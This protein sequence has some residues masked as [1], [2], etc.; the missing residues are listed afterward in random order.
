M[1]STSTK[2]VVCLVLGLLYAGAAASAQA[3]TF[4]VGI[5]LPVQL[6]LAPALEPALKDLGIG[7][8]NYYLKTFVNSQ[9]RPVAETGP[10][11]LDLVGRLGLDWSIA[12]Y[13][14][15]PPDD[16][17]RDAVAASAQAGR[18]GRFRGV[19]F[20][21]LEHI[22]LLNFNRPLPLADYRGFKDLVQAEAETIAGFG[23][24]RDKF[25][26]LGSP[27]VATHVF[28]V[29][30]HAAARAGFTPCPKIQKEMYSMVSLAI[31]LGAAKEYGRDLWVDAD[32][33]Y[34]D[35]I[36]GHSPDELKCNLLLAYWMGADLVYLEGAGFNL[37]PVGKQGTPFS[38]VNLIDDE[39]FQL[40]PHGEV[41]RWFTHDYLPAHPRPWT[42]RD[43]RPTT[44]IVR[45]DDTD[46]G[47]RL[48]D[49]FTRGLYGTENLKPDADTSAWFQIWNLLTCGRTGLDGITWFKPSRQ[50]ANFEWA[51]RKGLP[52]S[53]LSRPEQSGA[54]AFWTPLSGVVVYDHRVAYEQ[55]Q[56]VPLLY[57]TGNE[58]SPETLE[59]LRRCVREGAVCV[60]WG[61]LARRV[62][63][64]E[65]AGG[66]MVTPEGKGKWVITE[67]F[68]LPEVLHQM[69]PWLGHE[70]E[71]RYRFGEHTLVLHKV[72]ENQVRVEVDGRVEG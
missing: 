18:K 37:L 33:W 59:A 1:R 29:L 70:D 69:W 44:A 17:V 47:Q 65:W 38:L 68:G 51:T 25:T 7:Y 6:P 71:I 30:L 13:E 34:Y 31:G 24:L 67:D 22:R 61:P 9:D 48:L 27:V 60:A 21:E 36:P 66:V 3:P 72:T 10:A 39:H 26:P 56:G 53:W 63:L 14:A 4:T 43:V 62:G 20:D 19:V 55:L 35:L 15:D 8:V 45:F 50:P 28:P 41:L 54:H 16:A 11:M 40:T 2:R 64:G 23:R 5:E 57:L 32:L 46:Y 49:G 52:L 42:F 12:T 58:V